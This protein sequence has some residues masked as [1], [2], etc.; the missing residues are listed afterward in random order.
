VSAFLATLGVQLEREQDVPPP[1]PV[2]SGPN[3]RIVEATSQIGG[4]PPGSSPLSFVEGYTDHT[5]IIESP[6]AP[7]SACNLSPDMLPAP[8]QLNLDTIPDVGCRLIHL[9]ESSPGSPHFTTVP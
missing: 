6:R 7:V 2:F 4:L 5:A 3:D 9:L 8:D 1:V